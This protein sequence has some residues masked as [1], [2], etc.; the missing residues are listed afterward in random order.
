MRSSRGEYFVGLDHVRAIAAFLVFTWHFNHVNNGHFAPPSLFPLSIFT[1]GHI[2]VALFMTLSGYLFAKLSDGR[3]LQY[4]PFLWNRLLRLFPLL[5]VSFFLTGIVQVGING[6]PITDYAGI[7]LR[8]FVTP[9]WPN[10]GWSIAVE[11][12]FY[13]I[14]PLLLLLSAKRSTNLLFLVLLAMSGRYLY[15]LING[16]VQSIAYWTLAGCIDQFAFGI[17]AFKLRDKL[18]GRHLVGFLTVTFLILFTYY[19]DLL[20]GFYKNGGYPSG[21]PIWITAPF[22]AGACFAVLIAWYDGSFKLRDEGFSGLLAKVG[23]CSYSIY[24][25]HFFIVFLA[26]DFINE[27]VFSLSN[28]IIV[29]ATSCVVFIGFVPIAYLSFLIIELPPMRFRRSYLSSRTSNTVSLR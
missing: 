20:G 18:I 4:L 7:L 23:A 25:L 6:L 3:T 29:L 21:S 8:G 13:L 26:G 5:L 10:G 2:G 27:N 12:H 16:E 17:L 22:L 19:F 9:E 14:L 15:W 28:S 24:L 11:L 1:E